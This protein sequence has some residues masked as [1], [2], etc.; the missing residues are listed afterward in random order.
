MD[1][2]NDTSD[3]DMGVETVESATKLNIHHN[4]I[5]GFNGDIESFV[6]QRK[7]KGLSQSQIADVLGY[8]NTSIIGHFEAGVKGLDSRGYTL[9]CLITDIHPEYVLLQDDIEHDLLLVTAPDG[10][11]IRQTRLNAS[12]MT[13]PK[14]AKLLGLSSKTLVSNY[15][16]NRKN[17][18][19]QNWTIFLLITDQHPHYSIYRRFNK[20]VFIEQPDWVV[21]ASIDSD[22]VARGHSVPLAELKRDGSIWNPNSDASI[23]IGYGYD[24]RDWANSAIART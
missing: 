18:S 7:S 4:V 17:P 3:N 5:I 19:V 11:D 12:R 9:F 14:M 23:I 6:A 24:S 21:S 1:R 13:Q 2:N 22:G 15:E 8:A 20:D 10:E 16:N